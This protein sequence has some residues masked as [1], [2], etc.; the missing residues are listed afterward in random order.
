MAFDKDCSTYW[1]DNCGSIMD[2]DYSRSSEFGVVLKCA[3]R[4]PCDF[5]L[6][7]AKIEEA[8]FEKTVFVLD[9]L[10]VDPA[11]PAVFEEITSIQHYER[12]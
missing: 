4:E 12:E 6:F 5:R 9:T 10:D 1:C 8:A 7:F 11:V 3:G 2:V